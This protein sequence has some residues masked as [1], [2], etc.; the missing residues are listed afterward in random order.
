VEPTF[1]ARTAF[2]PDDSS[3]GYAR[4]VAVSK[5]WDD[6]TTSAAFE[7]ANHAVKYLDR[8]A[9]STPADVDRGPKLQR[10][11]ARWVEAAFRRPVSDEER[12]RWVTNQFNSA[13]SPETA[14]KR[15]VL[16][17]LKSPQFLYPSLPSDR[18]VDFAIASRISYAAW[19][20]L[21]D[22]ELLQAAAAG[23]LRTRDQVMVQAMRALADP[24]AR[25]KMRH[26]LYQWLQ[27]SYV[28]D[29]QKDPALFPEFTP[30]LV[31]DL[32]TSLNLF[33]DDVVWNSPS[34]NR[35]LLLADFL[36]VNDRLAKFY[37]VPAPAAGEFGR[38]TMDAAQRS[39]V[40][41]HPYLL[42]AFSYKSATSPIHRGVFLTRNIVGRA[43]ISP[44]MAVAFNDAEFAPNLTMREKVAKLTRPQSC[45]S[46]HA[47]INPLGF[48]LEWYDPVGR[49]RQ[50][51]NGR[52]IDAVSSYLTDDGIEVRLTGA[53]D[54]AQFAANSEHAHHAFIE[55]LFHQTI[56]QPLMAYGPEALGELRR[57][58]VAG[59]FNI[60][61]HLAELIA[62]AALHDVTP[63]R[64]IVTLEPHRAP[65]IPCFADSSSNEPAC[66][67]PCYRSSRGCRVS[68]S[69]VQCGRVN[70]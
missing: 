52:A 13:P 35:E 61:K 2:P 60:P 14:V 54:V 20:S 10:F 53:R 23:R 39:G 40:I 64:D 16:L 17:A 22:E 27:I 28:D 12:T 18:S 65:S 41:T 8:F 29:L 67:P 38:V 42:A 57:Q 36:F 31:A 50:A 37:G 63:A 19:D 5:A 30:D 34:G 46:C 33:L 3:L 49:F 26:F 69:P 58:F 59:D 25:A 68:P 43:L 1:V 21:P 15:I 9:H 70:G 45:Q 66:R 4:G 32:R 62:L 7:A 24:R 48:S 6:A 55:Q 47:V 44:P 56:K 51:E 11:A